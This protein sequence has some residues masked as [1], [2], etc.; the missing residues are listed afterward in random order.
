MQSPSI[1]TPST[2][3]LV[4]ALEKEF[5]DIRIEM[6]RLTIEISEINKKLSSINIHQ[7]NNI[8]GLLKIQN[9]PD[10]YDGTKGKTKIFNFQITQ[11]ILLN[12]QILL[13]NKMKIATAGSFLT[14]TAAN[15]YMNETNS[16]AP[17]I[18]GSFENFIKS[19]VDYFGEVNAHEAALNKIRDLRCKGAVSNLVIKFNALIID[20][21]LNETGK[22]DLFKEK[23]PDRVLDLMVTFPYLPEVTELTVYQ[24]YAITADNRIYQ[25]ELSKIKRKGGQQTYLSTTNNAT[26][27]PMD[28]SA[29]AA[30]SKY[31]A[32][33]AGSSKSIYI[34]YKVPLDEKEKRKLNGQCRYCGGKT[35]GGTPTN[36]DTCAK[37]IAKKEKTA[38]YL[39]QK[40]TGNVPRRN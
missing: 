28:L 4:A 18:N 38:A 29:M 2:E 39:L 13:N 10:T 15:W 34:G 14:G 22:I 24:G 11:F 20:V 17:S 23:L 6:R 9:K 7:N 33:Q 31:T 37:V 40:S 25:N 36:A 5:N 19:I 12:S 26:T 3:Q 35:C 21:E 27:T 16:K 8:S 32:S 30:T 1:E